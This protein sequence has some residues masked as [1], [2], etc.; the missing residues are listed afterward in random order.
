MWFTANLVF[1][2][3]RDLDVGNVLLWQEIIFLLE[4]A[5]ED[6]ASILAQSVGTGYEHGYVAADGHP[7]SWKL[8][9]VERICEVQAANLTTGVELFSRFIDEYKGKSRSAPATSVSP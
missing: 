7:V 5:T 8:V 2:L 1:K 3:I 4:A 6:Q 9:A